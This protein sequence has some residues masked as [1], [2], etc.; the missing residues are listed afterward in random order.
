MHPSRPL[1]VLVLALLAGN[2]AAQNGSPNTT[3]ALPTPANRIVGLWQVQVNVGPCANPNIRESFLALSNYHAG[4]TLS[5]TNMNPP[6]TRGPG[7]G[8]WEHQ[9]HGLYKTRFQFARYLPDGSFDGLL[10]VQPTVIL[11][12]AGTSYSADVFAQVLDDEGNV[13][14]DVCGTANG[15]R[16]PIQ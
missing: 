3:G 2:V 5:D 12:A 16:V 7:F 14:L 13:L 11:N 15:E 6:T 8:I 9:G 10:D 4:G 1:A